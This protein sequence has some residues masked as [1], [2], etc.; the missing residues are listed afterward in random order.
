MHEPLGG[1]GNENWTGD[2]THGMCLG[3]SGD[4]LTF[5]LDSAT[6]HYG[7]VETRMLEVIT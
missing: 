1:V 7:W 2:F 6:L 5:V 4:D 3:T